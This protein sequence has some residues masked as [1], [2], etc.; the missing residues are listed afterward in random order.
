VSIAA[1]VGRARDGR[2]PWHPEQR[3]TARDAQTASTRGRAS[4]RTGD[5]ADLAVVE[6][7]PFGSDADVLRTMPVALTLLGGRETHRTL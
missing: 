3:L 1:A 5:V 2:E 6:H 7:D 4:V